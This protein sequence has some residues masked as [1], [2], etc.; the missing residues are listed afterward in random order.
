V[1]QI[2]EMNRAGKKPANLKEDVIAEKVPIQKLNSDL[3]QMDQKFK[4]KSQ[5]KKKKKK[6]RHGRDNRNPNQ[7]P[8]QPRNPR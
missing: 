1:N 4:D 8:N 7:N 5:S 3:A 2:L 6:R